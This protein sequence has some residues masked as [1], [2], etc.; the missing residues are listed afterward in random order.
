MARKYNIYYQIGFDS[1]YFGC[2]QIAL[3]VIILFQPLDIFILIRVNSFSS[4]NGKM[5]LELKSP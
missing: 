5:V 2:Q 1:E 3:F 4:I